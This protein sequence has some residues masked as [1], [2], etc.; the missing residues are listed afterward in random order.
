MMNLF[1]FCIKHFLTNL[2]SSFTV[3]VS[4]YIFWIISFLFGVTLQLKDA[5]LESSRRFKQHLENLHG[6][7][8]VEFSN[9]S[10]YAYCDLRRNRFYWS[11]VKVTVTTQNKSL[12]TSL[13]NIM[14]V[15]QCANLLVLVLWWAWKESFFAAPCTPYE[16]NNSPNARMCSCLASFIEDKS[17]ADVWMSDIPMYFGQHCVLSLSI[18]EWP[19]F[20]PSVRNSVCKFAW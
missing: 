9:T 10:N 11:K 16:S 18:T 19:K 7:L 6:F 3:T 12:A 17:Y 1:Y 14:D 5:I 4:K 8:E 13:V 15:Y 20:C 2:C